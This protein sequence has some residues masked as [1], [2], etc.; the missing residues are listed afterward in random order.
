MVFMLFTASI[1]SLIIILCIDEKGINHYFLD[2]EVYYILLKGTATLFF[3]GLSL[4]NTEVFRAL[5]KL[6]IAELFRNIL[7]YIP[8]IIGSILLFYWHKET[9]LVDVFLV[10]FVILALLS[11]I[12]V[13]IY[14]KKTEEI[15]TAEIFTKRNF[16]KNP[17]QLR[18][19]EWPCFY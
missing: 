11:T 1:S 12:F 10:G 13:L 7:K 17:I 9:Y 19:A 16:H 6:Y 15:K 3:Y 4:F 2:D 5:D 18:L 8:L 14:F